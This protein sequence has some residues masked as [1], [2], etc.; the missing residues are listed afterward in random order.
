MMEVVV[1]IALLIYLAWKEYNWRQE[2]QDLL[3]MIKSKDALELRDLK[4]A[5]NTKV[6][7]KPEK[8]SD[9]VPTETLPDD[10]WEKIVTKS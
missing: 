8:P 10:E 4:M 5:R 3:D 1:I 2:K 7:I 9:F 6:E